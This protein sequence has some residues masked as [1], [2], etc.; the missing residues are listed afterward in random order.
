MLKQ[1]KKKGEGMEQ[2]KWSA[3][4][5][6]GGIIKYTDFKEPGESLLYKLRDEIP[7][8]KLAWL[9]NK[10][11]KL[12]KIQVVL[13]WEEKRLPDLLTAGTWLPLKKQFLKSDEFWRRGSR[14]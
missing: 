14:N 11:I 9:V 4:G 10:S 12:Q 2:I 7:L 3:I 6:W 13:L 5:T 1:T 8:R